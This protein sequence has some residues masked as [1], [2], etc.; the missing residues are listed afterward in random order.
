MLLLHCV[1]VHSASTI[2]VKITEFRKSLNVDSSLC[3]S[4]LT[5]DGCVITKATEM[6]TENT[7]YLMPF[8]PFHIHAI[9]KLALF[10]SQ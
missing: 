8:S 5:F 6:R 4:L 3:V 10:P 9:L 7:D 1:F 2:D